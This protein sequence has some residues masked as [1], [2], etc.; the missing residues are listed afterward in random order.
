M[1]KSKPE[2]VSKTFN[3]SLVSSNKTSRIFKKTS[4]HKRITETYKNK[5]KYKNPS[6]VLDEKEDVTTKIPMK[7]IERRN[8]TDIDGEFS[9]G[10]DENLI[11]GED[12]KSWLMQLTER[13]RELELYNRF[14]RRE[15][16][17]RRFEI[18]K[19]LRKK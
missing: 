14:E 1:K 8:L 2:K 9:D 19:K 5:L 13:E 16:L 7:Q 6:C 17:K 12:D 15:C 10:Y 18:W 11:G 4:K 3:L